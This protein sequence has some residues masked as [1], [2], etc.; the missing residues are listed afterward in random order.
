M[1]KILEKVDKLNREVV[2]L[3]LKGKLERATIIAREA[4]KIGR[5]NLSKHPILADSLNN[6]AESYQRQGYFSQ[7]EPL[8]IEALNLRKV[9]LELRKNILR[10]NNLSE[11]HPDIANT[12]NNLAEI[13]FAQG[14]YIEAEKYYS[15]ALSMRI[16]SLG[17]NHPDVALSLN[18]LAT[19]YT[20]TQRPNQAFTYRIQASEIN[21]KLISNVFAFSSENDRLAFIDKIRNNFDLF[22]SLIYKY[23]SNSQTAIQQAFDFILKRKGLSA[24]SLTAQNQAIYNGRYPHLT[25]QFRQLSE[26]SSQIIHLTFLGDRTAT[27]LEYHAQNLNHY[28]INYSQTNLIQLQA[29]Y[30]NLQ[31]QIAT[32]V[33]E[34]QLSEQIPNRHAV[35]SALP[36]NSV[37]IEFVHFELFDFQAIQANRETQWQPHRYSIY[38]PNKH[39]IANRSRLSP[40]IGKKIKI[41]PVQLV[42]DCSVKVLPKNSKTPNYIRGQKH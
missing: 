8:H 14:K 1:K 5:E 16:K 18:N 17:E 29:Q 42:L 12:L 2:Q 21:D 4:V 34:I 39:A 28:P 9:L 33:P 7:A 35:A 15:S 23:L 32:Q 38:N 36:A 37:L 31:K 11:E 19:L 13:Y 20:A 25:E 22:L 3:V 27:S 10:E 41:Y 6:L 26:L 24:A 40:K 30:D